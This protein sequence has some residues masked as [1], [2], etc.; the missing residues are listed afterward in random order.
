MT[1]RTKDTW[2]A[3]E[4]WT[5]IIALVLIAATLVV[6]AVERNQRAS[7]DSRQ[8]ETTRT[9]ECVVRGV[10]EASRTRAQERG[11]LDQE[12]RELFNAAINRIRG[13]CPPLFEPADR[14]SPTA[15]RSPLPGEGDGP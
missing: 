7:A 11:T 5:G 14:P 3:V 10:L 4:R 12:T 2:H 13:G 1:Q 6:S 15:P 9:V 8:T